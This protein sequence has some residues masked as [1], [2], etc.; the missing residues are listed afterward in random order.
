MSDVVRVQVAVSRSGL[1]SRRQALEWVK[2]GRVSVNGEVIVEP[3]FAVRP[4]HDTVS[5][6][7]K[8]LQTK[9]KEYLCL[10]KPAGY[11]TTKADE[12]APRKVTDLLPEGL[13]HLNPVGRLDKDTEGLLLM[14]ND[15]EVLH[16]MTHP[17]FDVGKHY[18]V[19]VRGDLGPLDV[20]TLAE[21]VVL[22]GEKTSPAQVQI[23]KNDGKNTDFK[24]TIHEGWNRQIRRMCEAVGCKVR[25]LKR[26]QHGPIVLGDLPKG[27]WRKLKM[28]EI[29]AL[30]ALMGK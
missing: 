2:N 15:G 20:Q 7:G 19:R 24:I 28:K 1:C 14:T 29:Q 22:E 18:F 8:P 12:H 3:S 13:R 11:V 5:V 27:K 16:V 6:D 17:R 21:G 10:H 23:L 30:R 25:Y 9:K 4:G 26:L